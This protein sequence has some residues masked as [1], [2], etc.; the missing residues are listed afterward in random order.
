MIYKQN[1][2]DTFQL[3]SERIYILAFNESGDEV[4]NVS[5]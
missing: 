2:I 3:N 1:N 4:S 5:I